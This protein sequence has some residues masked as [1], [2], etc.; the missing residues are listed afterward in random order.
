MI[1]IKD[2]YLLLFSTIFFLILFSAC[3]KS[4]SYKKEIDSIMNPVEQS[5]L[6]LADKLLYSSTEY[7]QN[8]SKEALLKPL[9]QKKAQL[10]SELNDATN[11]L[12]RIK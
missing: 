9:E 6:E 2:I 8:L 3:N 4:D 10:T 7:R 12:D 1:K 5:N 11:Q